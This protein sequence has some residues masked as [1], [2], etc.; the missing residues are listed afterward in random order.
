MEKKGG[1]RSR[2]PYICREVAKEWSTALGIAVLFCTKFFL[3]EVRGR[4]QRHISAF[5]GPK[6]VKLELRAAHCVFGQI[7]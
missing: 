1:G 5:C 2:W 6:N 4:D 7:S 3:Q